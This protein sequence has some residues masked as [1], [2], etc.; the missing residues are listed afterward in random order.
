MK[1]RRKRFVHYGQNEFDPVK[2][3]RGTCHIS[4]KPPIGFWGSPVTAYYSWEEYCK[5]NNLLLNRLNKKFYFHLTASARI[6]KVRKVNDILPYVK[7][8]DSSFV[9]DFS[10]IMRYYDGMELS[11][12]KKTYNNLHYTFF[13][14]WDV[15]SIVVWNMNCIVPD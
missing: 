7:E 11:H 10:K 12:S 3:N 15:D 9:I 4:N 14:T 13:Y 2:Y 1:V 8:E 6:L 5:N